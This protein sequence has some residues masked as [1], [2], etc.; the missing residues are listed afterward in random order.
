MN[1]RASEVKSKK[2]RCLVMLAMRNRPECIPDLVDTLK[3]LGYDEARIKTK[4]DKPMSLQA[5]AAENRRKRKLEDM[6]AGALD[7]DENE[8][9]PDCATNVLP[10]KD[11]MPPRVSTVRDLTVAAL[12]DKV[13]GRFGQ[14]LSVPNLKA[15]KSDEGGSKE[16]IL[17]LLTFA[18]GVQPD[19]RLSGRMLCFNY[20]WAYIHAESLKREKRWM[21][22]SL[23][24][25]WEE[26]G[27]L[28]IEGE[29]SEPGSVVILH[30]FTEAEGVVHSD[31]V[32]EHQELSQLHIAYNWNE[33]LVALASTHPAAARQSYLLANLF[34]QKMVK[35]ESAD[36]RELKVSP[37]K[38]LKRAMTSKDL[39]AS[40]PEP[41]VK[42]TQNTHTKTE[43]KEEVAAKLEVSHGADVAAGTPPPQQGPMSEDE[44]HMDLA[45]ALAKEM[46]DDPDFEQTAIA[47]ADAYFDESMM[48]PPAE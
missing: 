7:E 2:G 23:P 17:R 42:Q 15:I 19:H 47:I 10:P 36:S 39:G 25:S 11:P 43:L 4:S 45:G 31:D 29:G 14:T 26:E 24:P 13:V 33:K 32:P 28:A 18:S 48:A 40:T 9:G 16:G 6:D 20:F 46:K 37:A 41:K 38:M 21:L 22:L 44:G 5:A 30:R 3:S 35:E 27:L 34:T 12:R 8:L 1:R